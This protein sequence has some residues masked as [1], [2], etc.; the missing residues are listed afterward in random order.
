MTLISALLGIAADRL[1][2]QLHEYRRYEPFLVYVDWVRERLSGPAWEHI[3]GLLLLLLPVWTAVVLVQSWTSDWLFGLVG[4]L[5]YV[6]VL[7]Y[8]LGPRDLGADVD[9]YCQAHESGDSGLQQRAAAFFLSDDAVADDPEHVRLVL[10][11]L[12]EGA[13]LGG[14]ARGL[15]VGLSAEQGGQATG[16]GAAQAVSGVRPSG[17]SSCRSRSPRLAR[18]STT[19][20]S[21]KSGR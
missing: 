12:R 11:V 19:Y 1:L 10:G 3:G 2:P 13:L 20:C 8:C 16:P 9:T 5:F 4:L 7:V 14:H 15:G 21:S 6:A 17:C 18:G